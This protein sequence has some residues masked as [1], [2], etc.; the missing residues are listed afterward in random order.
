MSNPREHSIPTR[1]VSI[2]LD[3]LFTEDSSDESNFPKIDDSDFPGS[4]SEDWTARPLSHSEPDG[5]QLARVRP[6][7]SACYRVPH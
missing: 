3:Q 6:E 4:T 7:T 1:D 5:Y 2:T